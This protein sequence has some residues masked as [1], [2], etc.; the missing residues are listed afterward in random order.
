M[1]NRVKQACEDLKNVGMSLF[2]PFH[3]SSLMNFPTCRYPL[4]LLKVLAPV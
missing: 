3:L 2:S 1:Y 4:K